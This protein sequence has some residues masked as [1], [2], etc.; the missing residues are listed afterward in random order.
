MSASKISFFAR[1]GGML[2]SL[3]LKGKDKQK[4]LDISN[5]VGDVAEAIEEEK[6]H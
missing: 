3:F 4:S 2:S 6:R 5:Q 1:L